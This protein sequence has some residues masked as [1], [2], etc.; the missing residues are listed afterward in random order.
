M[1]FTQLLPN[2]TFII[3]QRMAFTSMVTQIDSYTV[4]AALVFMALVEIVR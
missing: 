1:Q 4:K 3:D 2:Y